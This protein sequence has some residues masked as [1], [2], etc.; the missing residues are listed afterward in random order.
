LCPRTQGVQGC[1]D[2]TSTGFCDAE[3]LFNGTPCILNKFNGGYGY[4]LV[5]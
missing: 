5:K 3:Q 2:D 4:R 1:D